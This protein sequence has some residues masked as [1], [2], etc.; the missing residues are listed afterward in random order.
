LVEATIRTWLAELDSF[1]FEDE[2][3]ALIAAAAPSIAATAAHRRG[4]DIEHPSFVSH[5]ESHT[6]NDVHLDGSSL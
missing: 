6:E 2:L 5:I 1:E 3:Q 4:A